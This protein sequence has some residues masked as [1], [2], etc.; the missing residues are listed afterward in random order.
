MP[1]PAFVATA[2][3]RRPLSKLTVRKPWFARLASIQFREASCNPSREAAARRS[4]N[5]SSPIARTR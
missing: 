1:V 3:I 5:S 2:R 4:S